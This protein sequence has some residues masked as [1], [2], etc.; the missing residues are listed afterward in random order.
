M[1]LREKYGL[2]M[3]EDSYHGCILNKR[4][5][6][7]IIADW[8]DALEEIHRTRPP[9]TMIYRDRMPDCVALMDPWPE[10][11]ERYLTQHLVSFTDMDLSFEEHAK[12][13]LALLDIPDHGDLIESLHCLF[14]LF[15]EFT[16]N[17]YFKLHD[18]H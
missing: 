11:V 17:S 1:L 15:A 8:L 6:Q 5:N 4:D 10:E 13:I 9:T 16:S 3:G 7:K 12:I 14:S 18:A 2:P